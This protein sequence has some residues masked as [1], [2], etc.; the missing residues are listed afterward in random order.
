M[1]NT[2]NVSLRYRQS[3]TAKTTNEDR[4]AIKK[5]KLDSSFQCYC[6][7]PQT[8]FDTSHAEDCGK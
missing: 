4:Q 3:R 8:D 2:K 7:L 1:C 5:Q 6:T